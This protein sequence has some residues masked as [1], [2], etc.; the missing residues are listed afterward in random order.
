MFGKSNTA[1]LSLYSKLGLQG[2]VDEVVDTNPKAK[3]LYERF[4]IVVIKKTKN[5]A[6]KF[7][8]TI[9][10]QNNR[11]YKEKMN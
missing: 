5:L 6:V 9:S 4:G 2:P 11:I 1:A 8:Y 7:V 3:A 10:I